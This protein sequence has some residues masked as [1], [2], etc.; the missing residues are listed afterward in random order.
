MKRI[1]LLLTLVS[2]YHIN[3][4]SQ[5]KYEMVVE[6]TNGTEIV[7]KTDEVVRVYFRETGG[8]SDDY[9]PDALVGIWTQ[10]HTG[11]G[12]SWYI[13]LKLDSNGEA[14]YTEW[15]YKR[16]PDWTYTGGAKWQ[17]SENVL[18]IYDPY[19]NLVYS[20]AFTLSSDGNTITFAGDTTGGHFSTL[21][22][23]FVKQQ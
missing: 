3:V 16:S 18:D 11:S 13:G 2:I 7:I 22:G 19:G 12:T 21:V 8:N 4:F 23:E 9:T 5:K 14:A 10:F 15:D 20:S 6:K 1:V 17:V